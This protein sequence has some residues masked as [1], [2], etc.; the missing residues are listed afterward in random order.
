ME[1]TYDCN[2][3]T[4][5]SAQLAVGAPYLSAGNTLATAMDLRANCA[6]VYN[7]GQLGACTGF[8]AAKG[9][10]EFLLRKKTG[11]APSM[12]ALYLYYYERSA[13]H[14]I[15]RDAGAQIVDSAFVLRSRGCATEVNCPYNIDTFENAPNANSEAEA[16]HYRVSTTSHL[17]TIADMIN[18]LCEG[19]VFIGGIDIFESFESDAVAASGIVPMPQP[20]EKLMGGHAVC[21]VGFDMKRGAFLVRNSWGADWGLDGYFWLPFQFVTSYGSDFWTARM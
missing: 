7:Q 2:R 5:D 10:L 18:C 11:N 19:Y 12:A 14:T 9:M 17:H 1:R 6:P 16:P 20:G 21:F 4:L 8:A 15:G 3:H 13:E